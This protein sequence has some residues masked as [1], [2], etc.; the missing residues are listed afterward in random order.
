MDKIN[1]FVNIRRRNVENL[2]QM[3]LK[4]FENLQNAS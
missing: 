3:G 1:W 4:Y 2:Q